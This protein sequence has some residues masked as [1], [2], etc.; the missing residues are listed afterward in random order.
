MKQPPGFVSKN[1]PS[2]VCKLDKALYGLK[3]APRAWYSRLCHKMQALGFVPSNSD[4]S[5]FIYNKSNTC[6]FVLIYVDDIIVTSSSDEAITG[7][8]KDLSADFALKD[9]GDLHFFL[10]IEVKRNNDG[11]HLSQE[12]YAT[13]LVKKA[14][15]KD[16]KP[17]PTPLSSSE[18]LS[19]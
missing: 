1:A 3:Q 12:K 2:Y 7:L 13:D 17:S 15:L 16:C 11:L 8:L 10:G 19:L 14:G 6:I 5:L 18:K 4:T 9:L